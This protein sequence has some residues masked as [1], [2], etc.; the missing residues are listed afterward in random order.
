MRAFCIN[1]TRFAL[2]GAVPLALLLLGYVYYDPFKVLYDY[3]DYSNPY[4]I[5][6]RDYISTE[7]FI[8]NHPKHD[9]NSYI[10]GSSRTIAFRPASWKKYLSESDNVFMFDASGESIYG[11][12]KKL[13]YLDEANASIDNALVVMCRDVTF[14][15]S[16]NHEG[17][18]YIKHPAC[19]G[20]SR[21]AFHFTFLQAYFTMRFLLCFYDYTFTKQFKPYMSDFIENR[22]VLY[23]PLTNEMRIV[24]QEEEIT[25][26]P[27]QYYEK[28][29]NLFYVRQKESVDAVQRIQPAHLLMLEEMKRIFDKHGTRY[30]IV[31][32]PLYEQVKFNPAD[33]NTIKRVFGQEVY[34]FSGRNGYTD[35]KTNYYETSHYRTSVGDDILRAVYN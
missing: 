12:Y 16:A 34:D 11:I 22:S 15:H 1:L 32:S 8:K 14:G 3:D 20:E 13:K 17:H 24:D 4:V 10:F 5:P 35:S 21:I 27:V 33:L 30:K 9:Y 23:D 26:H 29:A 28:R 7:T 25:V 6:N 31:I 2:I 19:S 18:L